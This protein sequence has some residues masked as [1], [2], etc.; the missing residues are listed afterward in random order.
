MDVTIILYVVRLRFT[1]LQATNA[2]RESRG[3]AVLFL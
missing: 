2:Q 1:L 3:I